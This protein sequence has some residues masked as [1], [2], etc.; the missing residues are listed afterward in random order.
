MLTLFEVFGGGMDQLQC[1]QLETTLF[2]ARDDVAN[3]GTLDA[4][5]LNRHVDKK[6]D[7]DEVDLVTLT[8]M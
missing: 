6:S 5:R 1:D 3:E 4:I 2:E 7:L 8:M